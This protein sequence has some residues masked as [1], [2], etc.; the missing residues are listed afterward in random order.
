V[1]RHNPGGAFEES[2]LRSLPKR[3]DVW[4]RKSPTPPRPA[5]VAELCAEIERRCQAA[6]LLELRLG[7]LVLA[8]ARRAEAAADS[9]AEPPEWA[10]ALV[11]ISSEMI[12]EARVPSWV[13]SARALGSQF[14]PSAGVDLMV[15]APAACIWGTSIGA[16]PLAPKQALVVFSLECKSVAEP[17]I[18][19]E[20]LR[21]T[22][23]Q[24]LLRCAAGGHVAGVLI[25]WR[26]VPWGLHFV[27]I[28]AWVEAREG[29]ARKSLSVDS[30]REAGVEIPDDSTRGRTARYWKMGEFMRKFGAEV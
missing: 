19:F 14:T 20:R 15:S 18:P 7:R 26:L 10:H 30:A 29:G 22:Q 6:K 23:E 1:K 28:R 27:P 5:P 12:G 16:A 3:A 24:E 13:E 17:R 4:R 21:K 9:L 25:E 11:A 2:I 8:E